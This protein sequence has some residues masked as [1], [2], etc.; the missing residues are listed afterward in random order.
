MVDP[1]WAPRTKTQHPSD[2]VQGAKL[3][4]HKTTGLEGELRDSGHSLWVITDMISQGKSVG[5]LLCHHN[6]TSVYR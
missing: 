1:N 4:C 5:G 3:K 6:G 2:I